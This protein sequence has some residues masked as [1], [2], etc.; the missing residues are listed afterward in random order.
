VIDD[1]VRGFWDGLDKV[2]EYIPPWAMAVW[3]IAA[4]VWLAT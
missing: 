3:G 4:A 1:I 2:F